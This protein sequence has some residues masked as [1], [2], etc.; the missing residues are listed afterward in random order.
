MSG[1][2]RLVSVVV[3]FVSL[4]FVGLTTPSSA[5]VGVDP[6]SVDPGFSNELVAVSADSPT[7]VWA[8]GNY[9]QGHHLYT[10]VERWD[11][12]SWQQIKAPTPPGKL[13]GQL[14]G[15]S[16]LSP[17]DV[18]AVGF[19]SEDHQ[20]R[21]WILHWDGHSWRRVSSPNPSNPRAPNWLT[22]VT[23]VS[24][25]DVWAVG[26]DIGGPTGGYRA[27][28]EHWDGTSWKVVRT[29]DLG[30]H[31]GEFTSVSAQSPTNVWAVGTAYTHSGIDVLVERWD[32]R[33]WTRW[34]A[35]SGAGQNW[36]NSV[37][38]DGPQDAWVAG[39]VYSWEDHL[40]RPVLLHWDGRSWTRT[41]APNP[42]A[43]FGGTQLTGAAAISPN[44]VWVVGNQGDQATFHTITEH[45]DGTRWSVVQPADLGDHTTSLFDGVTA[46]GAD[47]VF[48]VGG[49]VEG[50]RFPT[51]A[52]KWNGSTWTKF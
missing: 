23:A 41:S 18:W 35:P 16:A 7:D 1:A 42:G 38:V 29:P 31:G 52:E 36:V 21:T 37:S 20:M 17:T 8:V 28:A 3:G 46:T 6:A 22:G 45:W 12:S 51:L 47:D 50:S 39:W 14:S 32:G 2:P 48:A 33:T 34:Q 49:Y 43:R 11:G 44:D 15:V 26:W 40:D 30:V 10:L 5:S 4:L 13:G 25:T 9:Q 27:L 19:I 24:S